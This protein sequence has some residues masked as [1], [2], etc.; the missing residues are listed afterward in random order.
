MTILRVSTGMPYI[1]FIN[2]ASVLC[3][4]TRIHCIYV[5]KSIQTQGSYNWKQ[6]KMATI[7]TVLLIAFF[8]SLCKCMYIGLFNNDWCTIIEWLDEEVMARG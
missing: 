1:V 3:Q 5:T 6:S 7:N 2:S 8:I 4:I